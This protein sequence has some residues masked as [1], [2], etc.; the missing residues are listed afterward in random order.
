MRA[1]SSPV[2]SSWPTARRPSNTLSWHATRGVPELP[3]P[4]KATSPAARK[5]MQGNRSQDTRPEVALRSALHRRGLRFRKH[6]RALAAL[7][8]RPDVVFPRERVAVFLDGCFW[9]GCA[10]H[11][12]LPRANRAYWEAK[13]RVNR[14]RDRRNDSA[15]AAHGWLVVRVWEHEDPEAG[16]NAVEEVVRRRRVPRGDGEAAQATRPL[17]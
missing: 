17:K 1:S 6:R 3:V 14:E 7:A 8:C 4:P 16:A 12:V 15:L 10:S 9:H 5:V 13:V 11:G 2:L